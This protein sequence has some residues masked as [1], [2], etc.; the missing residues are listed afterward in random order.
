MA[1][2]TSTMCGVEVGCLA[3][4]L[5][6]GA[7]VVD[8]C[9]QT[10]VRLEVDT[11]TEVV[12]NLLDSY[13]E[14]VPSA[15]NIVLARELGHDSNIF[16]HVCGCGCMN[17]RRRALK[18]RDGSTRAVVKCVCRRLGSGCERVRGRCEVPKTRFVAS[19]EVCEGL[20]CECS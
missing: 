12:H 3:D 7:E 14:K 5:L 11:V 10:H 9:V 20:V 2:L 15:L 19:Q 8:G 1:G 17:G 16:S 18:V 6:S 4:S 13:G